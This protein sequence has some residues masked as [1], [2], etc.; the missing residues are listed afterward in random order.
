M[1]FLSVMLN[2]CYE[3]SFYI[4]PVQAVR[5]DVCPHILASMRGKSAYIQVHA[6]VV[7]HKRGP[8]YQSLPSF[9][10]IK[11]TLNVDTL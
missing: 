5:P 2:R 9:G 11:D 6:V 7:H 1:R 3:C 8:M 4:K 10:D